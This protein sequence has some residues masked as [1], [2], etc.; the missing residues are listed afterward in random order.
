V[1]VRLIRKLANHLNG[2]DVSS[3]RVGDAI[4]VSNSVG[5]LL[6]AEGWAEL[7]DNQVPGH[8]RVSVLIVDD[9]PVFRQSLSLFLHHQGFAPHRAS[10]IEEALKIIGEE[11]VDA[12]VLDLSLPDPGGFAPSGIT[13]LAYLRSCPEHAQLPVVVF[14]GKLLTAE[15]ENR[16]RQYGATLFYKPGPY[17]ALVK[18]LPS[19][20]VQSSAA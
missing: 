14:T 5:A 11:K 15:E 17:A 10:T 1:Q 19:S 12:L 7:V 18:C 8:R 6:V 4:E 2:V 20:T 9:E 13:L 16:I 3:V